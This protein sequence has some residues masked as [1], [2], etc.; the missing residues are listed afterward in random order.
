MTDRTRLEISHIFLKIGINAMSEQKRD[1]DKEAASWDQE[2]GRVKLASDV[3]EAI[4]DEISLTSTMDVLDFGCGTGLLT[5]HIQPLVHTITAVDSSRG[6]IDILQSK[7]QSRNLTNVKIQFKD[8]AEGDSLEGRYHLIFSS[9]TFHHIRDISPLLN[10]FSKVLVPQG[11]LCIADLDPDEGRFHGNKEGVF[12]QGFDRSIL[13][14]AFMEAGF[15][16]IRDQ[17]AAS[18]K[19][20]VPG[21]GTQEFTVFLMTGRKSSL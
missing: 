20:H 19:K 13:R 6:M 7:V 14:D 4:S 8:L 21:G 16:D 9:M 18:V 1:F 15:G 5:L 2:P 10:Q 17:T 3:A 12:H 11:Y